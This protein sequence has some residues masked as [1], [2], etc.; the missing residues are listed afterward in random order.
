MKKIT[1]Y[2]DNK[3]DGKHEVSINQIIKEFNETEESKLHVP[4][5]RLLLNFLM[6]YGSFNVLT[7]DDWQD[8]Y[9]ERRKQTV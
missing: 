1:F 6:K 2:R 3:I 7:D 5:E 9:D 8:L 4:F